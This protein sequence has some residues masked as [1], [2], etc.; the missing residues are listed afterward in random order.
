MFLNANTQ[1]FHVDGETISALQDHRRSSISPKPRPAVPWR[2]VH[3]QPAVAQD[4]L[5]SLSTEVVDNTPKQVEGPDQVPLYLSPCSFSP[6]ETYLWTY[7][8][9]YITPQCV[10][11]PDFNPYRD[12]IL[13]IAATSRDGPLFHCVLAVAANQLH[14]V[15]YTEYKPAMWLHRAKAL[16]LLRTKLDS[17]D[18]ATASKTQMWDSDARDQ[19]IATTL[20]LC[21][22][23]VSGRIS[24]RGG[25]CLT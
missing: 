12:I 22:F 17:L 18:T 11:N 8:D 2:S 13:K 7:F 9:R 1:D 3:A 24:S 19:I 5:L 20:M 6:S 16:H 4:R 15:G 21:F 23:D 14:S 10:L 25:H